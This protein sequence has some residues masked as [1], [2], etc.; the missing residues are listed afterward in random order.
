MKGRASLNLF[1]RII[2]STA[3]GSGEEKASLDHPPCTHTHT[4]KH[5]GCS[6]NI[7]NMVCMHIIT[8]SPPWTFNN[9][10]DILCCWVR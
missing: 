4:V 3:M 6:N 10:I 9:S 8:F 2:A 1:R 7:R 5:T